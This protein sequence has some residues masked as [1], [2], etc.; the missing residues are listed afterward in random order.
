MTSRWWVKVVALM[1]MALPVFSG[2]ATAQVPAPSLSVKAVSVLAD[3]LPAAEAAFG[4]TLRVEIAGLATSPSVDP[5]TLR[6]VLGGT[7][8]KGIRALP[9]E[10]GTDVVDFRLQRMAADVA[11]WQ[12][13][14][15]SPP[16]NG[17]RDL[18]V[19]VGYENGTALPFSGKTPAV[20]FV[21]FAGG[22]VWAVAVLFLV[23]LGLF[24]YLAVKSDI[25]RDPNPPDPLGPG[26]RRPYSMARCQMA[27]WLFLVTGCFGFI[28]IV[29]GDYN[30]IVT[31]ETLPLLGISGATALAAVA[32]DSNKTLPDGKVWPVSVSFLI[33]ILSDVNGVTVQRFQLFVWTI[34]L[35]I[36]FVVG[37]YR[38]LALP[39]FDTSLLALMGIS[40]GL[41]I[42]FKWPENQAE[43]PKT[44]S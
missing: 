14:L 17:V 37:A 24:G 10:A 5:S 16:L 12:G 6:L 20:P 1:A 8:L 21:I 7:L 18:S 15:G 23:A 11:A 43:A 22:W 25:V 40:S 41:Y 26:R 33:D 9:H 2:A 19:G 36:V 28:A 38:T 34:V 4:R 13:L 42:G 3:G 44:G 27:W 35:G 32:I 29:T 31:P 39:Q 30:G